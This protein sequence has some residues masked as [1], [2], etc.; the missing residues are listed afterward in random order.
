[1]IPGL[2]VLAMAFQ[3]I[4]Q[5]TVTYYKWVSA[6]ENP[7]G[8]LVSLYEE[9]ETITGSFQP[10]P[11][12]LYQTQGLDFQKIYYTFYTTNNLLDVQRDTSG[13]V[14]VFEGHKFSCVSSNDW[15]TLDGWVGMLCVQND[16]LVLPS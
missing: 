8:Q 9:P 13:D 4:A 3:A 10:V 14:L 7:I 15:Y 16:T 5:Q 6:G 12:S 2:N 1:M 11:R